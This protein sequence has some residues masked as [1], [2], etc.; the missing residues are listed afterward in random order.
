M[1][2]PTSIF[3]VVTSIFGGKR[4]KIVC[5]QGTTVGK[6]ILAETLVV[7][8]DVKGLVVDADCSADSE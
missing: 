1:V 8:I 4:A 2:I 6:Q 7:E 3:E 5:H